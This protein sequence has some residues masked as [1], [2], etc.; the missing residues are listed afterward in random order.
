MLAEKTKIVAIDEKDLPRV[1]ARLGVYDDVI[2]GRAKC[3]ICGRQLT[4][5]NIGVIMGVNG[6]PVL[7]CDNNV[8]I[9]KASINNKARKLERAFSIAHQGNKSFGV[10]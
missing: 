8:C 9:A 6:K 5:D 1:L 2:N 7:I 10:H 3:Y 4:M